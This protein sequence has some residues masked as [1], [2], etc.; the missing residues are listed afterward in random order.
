MKVKVIGNQAVFEAGFPFDVLK[1]VERFKPDALTIKDDDGNVTFRVS[2]N[3]SGKVS[4]Y[5]VEFANGA[6]G[7]AYAAV[8]IPTDG[9]VADYLFDRFG[10]VISAVNGIEEGISGKLDEISL[11]RAA[12]RDSIEFA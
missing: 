3:G 12:L 6:N 4:V 7:T 2:A 11:M 5:G 1:E 10:G 9:D 8:E